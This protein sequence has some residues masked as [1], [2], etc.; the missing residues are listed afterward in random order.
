MIKFKVLQNK[1]HDAIWPFVSEFFKTLPFT[2]ILVCPNPIAVKACA[3]SGC[4]GNFY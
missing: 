4:F 3:W 2:F 1:M